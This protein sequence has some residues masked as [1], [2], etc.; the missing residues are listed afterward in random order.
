[1]SYAGS[2]SR[3]GVGFVGE[4]TPG[5]FKPGMSEGQQRDLA[6]TL[7]PA[8][9]ADLLQKAIAALPKCWNQQLE[10]CADLTPGKATPP[11][12]AGPCQT[13]ADGWIG[14]FDKM[15]TAFQALPDCPAPIITLWPWFLVGLTPVVMIGMMFK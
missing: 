14:D 13:I 11:A 6:A 9:R 3:L 12:G 8:V 2:I 5:Y 4:A 10:D 1:M 7:S 15:R